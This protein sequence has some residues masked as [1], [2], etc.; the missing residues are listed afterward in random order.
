ML[1]DD[2]E[3]QARQQRRRNCAGGRGV[4]RDFGSAFSRQ[5]CGRFDLGDRDFALQQKRVAGAE[6]QSFELLGAGE[7]IGAGRDDDG[8]FPVRIDG[9]ERRP[10]RFFRGARKSQVDAVGGEQRKRSLG[11]SVFAIGA[12]QRDLCARAASSQ[13]LIGALAP[14]NRHII[15]AEHGFSRPGDALGAGDQVDIDR[16]EDNDHGGLAFVAGRRSPAF[17]I[18]QAAPMAIKSDL[19]DPSGL[20]AP[21]SRVMNRPRSPGTSVSRCVSTRMAP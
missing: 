12:H 2:E 14:G 17:I 20:R 4:Q 6:R 19:V 13:R 11:E 10:C 18:P 21:K 1:V 16:T 7:R 8:V 3:I 5:R 9:D 15:A